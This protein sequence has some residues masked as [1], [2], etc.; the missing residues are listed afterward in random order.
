M[1]LKE[2]FRYQKF[3]TGLLT[4]AFSSL[5]NPQPLPDY[6]QGTH[7]QKGQPRSRGHD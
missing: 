5:T 1:N 4:N 6:H 2:S 3:L 7:A